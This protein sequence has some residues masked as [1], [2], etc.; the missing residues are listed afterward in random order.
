MIFD[1]SFFY[2]INISNLKERVKFINYELA[3]FQLKNF[4]RLSELN[5]TMLF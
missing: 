2:I 3:F 5:G 4:L 1:K